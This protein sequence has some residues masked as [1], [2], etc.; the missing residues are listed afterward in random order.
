MSFEGIKIDIAKEENPNEEPDFEKLKIEPW[1]SSN[2]FSDR[3]K[4]TKDGKLIYGFYLSIN[5]LYAQQ[6]SADRKVGV[7]D[8]SSARLK[9][10]DFNYG[11]TIDEAKRSEVLSEGYDGVFFNG[12][13]GPEIALLVDVAIFKE[14]IT[15]LP[16]PILDKIRDRLP[17]PKSIEVYGDVLPPG[18]V[19][20]G[21]QY[22]FES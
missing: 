2:N 19:L 22:V 3:P 7:F 10:V 16:K 5:P 14:K 1:Y 17:I 4:E 12:M 8:V 15:P 6:Y 9:R 11:M 18:Y 20:R 21:D 13:N